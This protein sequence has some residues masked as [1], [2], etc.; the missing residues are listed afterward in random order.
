MDD[1]STLL[2][3]QEL[4][5]ANVKRKEEKKDAVGLWDPGSTLSFITFD[6]ATN[7]D[8]QGQPVE[9]EIVTVG[10]ILTKVKSRKY[11][12]SVFDAG[13]CDVRVEVLGIEK[14]STETNFVDME[15]LKSVFTD[16]NAS[17]VTCPSP[18]KV[19]LLLGFD[20]A[21]YHPVSVKCIG[22]LLLMRNRFGYIIAGTHPSV[23]ETA[24]KLVKHA[25]VL[26]MDSQI[27]QFYSIESLGVNCTPKCGGCRCGKCSTGGKDMTLLEEKEF[28]IIKNG[29]EFK[30]ATGRYE[31][32]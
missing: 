19:D 17:K 5:I 16:R 18:G 7:L 9:L 13:G 12:L 4:K 15:S 26:H 2:Q 30:A 8:L 21:A 22:H 1:Q 10:G 31:A 20:C 11:H 32:N 3:L 25:V 23:I 27:D 29:L 28:E 6:L 14:I 24:Q